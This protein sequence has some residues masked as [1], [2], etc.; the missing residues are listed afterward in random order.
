MRGSR[1]SSAIQGIQTRP[2]LQQTLS[3]KK[4]KK[5]TGMR[6]QEVRKWRLFFHKTWLQRKKVMVLGGRDAETR[7]SLWVQ[8]G[9]FQFVSFQRYCK[10]NMFNMKSQQPRGRERLKILGEEFLGGDRAC[11]KS[12]YPDDWGPEAP[13]GTQALAQH[14]FLLQSLFPIPKA[15]STHWPLKIVLGNNFLSFLFPSSSIFSSSSSSFPDQDRLIQAK[16]SVPRF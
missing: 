10:D 4:K 12:L 1:S 14:L 7:Q 5:C 13:V 2:E 3:K 15:N 11:S 9:W 6:E 16:G 8:G